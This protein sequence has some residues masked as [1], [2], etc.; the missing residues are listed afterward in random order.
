MSA[1]LPL[2]TAFIA[3]AL[4]DQWIFQLCVI[5]TGSDSGTQ[6]NSTT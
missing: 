4:L 3:G 6:I 1:P 2:V 5:Y